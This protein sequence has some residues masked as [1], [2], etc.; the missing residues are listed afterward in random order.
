MALAGISFVA[1]IVD[2]FKEGMAELG[3]VEGE[4][5]EYDVQLTE[6][7]MTKYESIIKKFVEDDVDLILVF[8]TEA[9][10]MAKQGTQGTDIPVLFDF[11]LVEE[12]GIVDSIREPGGN[13]TG[14]RYPGPDIALRRFEIMQELVPDI[15]L[16]NL[17][18]LSL[19]SFRGHR[20]RNPDGVTIR[21]ELAE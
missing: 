11:A 16:E 20:P 1:D 15:C 9:T 4:N 17:L 21:I 5:I 8:P 19:I 7:D 10:I 12:M 14:V 2:G 3:Y 6:F 13:I 18:L